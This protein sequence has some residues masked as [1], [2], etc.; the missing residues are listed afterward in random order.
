MIFNTTGKIGQ[1]LPGMFE[2]V[3]EREDG[4]LHYFYVTKEVYDAALRLKYAANDNISEM[5]EQLQYTQDDFMQRVEKLLPDPL[6]ILAPFTFLCDTPFDAED[7][8]IL[9]SL[10]FITTMIGNLYDFTFLPYQTRQG[11]KFPKVSVDQFINQQAVIMNSYRNSYSGGSFV[12]TGKVNGSGQA[13]LATEV[14][15]D[16]ETVEIV[17]A[18]DVDDFF[19]SIPGWNDPVDDGSSLSSGN[20]SSSTTETSSTSSG[21]AVGENVKEESNEFDAINSILSKYSK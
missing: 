6:H 9:S 13:V 1:F 7:D 11:I 20:N 8:F 10:A 17:E 4:L 19:A 18:L 16:G 15:E 21:P 3:K 2:L 12:G 14:D 5:L